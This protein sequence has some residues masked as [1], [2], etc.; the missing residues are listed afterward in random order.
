MEI[1]GRSRDSRFGTFKYRE[2]KKDDTD[3]GDDVGEAGTIT[4]L[5]DMYGESNSNGQH[6]RNNNNSNDGKFHL[7]LKV[8]V[9]VDYYDKVV[10]V[11]NGSGRLEDDL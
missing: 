2:R 6:T 9:L 5:Q 1:T 8:G 10:R 3:N 7:F 4:K 11:R